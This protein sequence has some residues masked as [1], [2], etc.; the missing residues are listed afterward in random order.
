MRGWLCAALLVIVAGWAPPALAVS[1]CGADKLAVLRSPPKE[2]DGAVLI[3]CHLTLKPGEV[4]TRSL[5]F[6]HGAVSN[7]VKV[8]CRG[9][10]LSH[11]SVNADIP[12]IN[13]QTYAWQDSDGKTVWE[14][15]RHISI[16]NC[17]L[18]G[19]INVI[20]MGGQDS[21][22]VKESS[23]SNANHTEILRQR[24]PTDITFDGLTIDPEDH[25]AVY[26]SMGVTGVTI[27]HSTFV[28]SSPSAV[29]YLDAEGGMNQ[30][31]DNQFKTDTPREVIAV[32]GSSENLIQGNVFGTSPHGGVFIYRNCGEGGTV[33]HNE[34]SKNDVIDNRFLDSRGPDNDQPH[35]W[36]ASRNGNR[37]YCDDDAG[38]P[39][40]SSVSDRDEAHRT[41]IKGNYF[42]AK[43]H[44]V[45]WGDGPNYLIDNAA[46]SAAAMPDDDE[47]GSTFVGSQTAD[48]PVPSTSC[49]WRDRSP[50]LL[51]D[52]ESLDLD[53]SDPKKVSCATHRLVCVK[54]QLDKRPSHCD[55]KRI[56][57]RH[58]KCAVRDSN[59]GCE[60]KLSCGSQKQLLALKA[61]CNLEAGQI[62][63][64]ALH[65]APWNSLAV[66]RPSDNVSDGHC[67]IG[68]YDIASHATQLLGFL[69]NPVTA[70]CRESD[71]NGGECRIEGDYICY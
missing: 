49:Y 47:Y 11:T 5:F 67:K 55:P 34:P 40:G 3:D 42:N 12:R 38:F 39:Y 37:P 50:M 10:T 33:R 53:L 36:I 43:A 7:G 69:A 61:R 22:A 66:D 60:K 16:K 13:V 58:F 63:S 32:D 17:K 41:G 57:E 27:R 6:N 9:A 18:K 35:I 21:P 56:S 15:T 71:S 24:A 2:G 23:R 45:A 31:L 51:R 20:G 65:K 25:I 1:A 4:I 14:P 68:G 44:A 54:G 64:G 29:L 46:G 62:K 59:E 70:G 26:L 8:D 48:G 19:N 30:I 28:G 52:G